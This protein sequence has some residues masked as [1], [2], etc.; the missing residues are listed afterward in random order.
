MW[1]Q[2]KGQGVQ[3]CLTRPVGQL[4][5]AHPSLGHGMISIVSLDDPGSCEQSLPPKR[6]GLQ[7][8][9]LTCTPPQPLEQLDQLPHG[10]HSPSTGQVML[11]H[12]CCWTPCPGHWCSGSPGG[13]DLWR[14]IVPV[15]HEALQELQ[16]LQGP[17]V[18]QLFSSADPPCGDEEDSGQSATPLQTRLKG[19][20]DPS[21]QVNSGQVTV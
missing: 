21:E 14:L 10:S 17:Q 11:K 18:L 6:G 16:G 5:L 13:Q 12:C 20:H 7:P 3:L 15:P 4:M 19:M 9:C 2:D 1:P 8:L